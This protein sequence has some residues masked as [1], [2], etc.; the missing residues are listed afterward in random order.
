MAVP[1]SVILKIGLEFLT[2]SKGNFGRTFTSFVKFVKQVT[3]VLFI[4]LLFFIIQHIG[5]LFRMF[6]SERYNPLRVI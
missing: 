2:I 5:R 3:D 1:K 4:G 6:S